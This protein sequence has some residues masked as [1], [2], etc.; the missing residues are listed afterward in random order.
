MHGIIWNKSGGEREQFGD[1]V[2]A[3]TENRRTQEIMIKLGA[4]KI[5]QRLF[6]KKNCCYWDGE[7]IQERLLIIEFNVRRKTMAALNQPQ[8]CF[9]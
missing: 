5:I 1:F 4:L 7:M 6:Y 3:W 8:V 9:Y 2:G